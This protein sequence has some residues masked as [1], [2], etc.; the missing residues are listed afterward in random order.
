LFRDFGVN[1]TGIG[2]SGF[3]NT[4]GPL[5]EARP[6]PDAEPLSARWLPARARGSQKLQFLRRQLAT[7]RPFLENTGWE[8]GLELVGR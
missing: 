1:S 7:L 8:E 2:I 3:R 4:Q 5:P 6:L